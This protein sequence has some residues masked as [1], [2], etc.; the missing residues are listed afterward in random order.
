VAHKNARADQAAML[1]DRILL[2]AGRNQVYATQLRSGPETGG[3]LVLR[4]IDD[5]RNVD[6]RRAAVG[7]KPLAEY[8]KEFGIEY[9][10]PK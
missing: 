3:K 2:S 10:A 4:P 7:L 9:V 6:A 5:A 1:E 8:L